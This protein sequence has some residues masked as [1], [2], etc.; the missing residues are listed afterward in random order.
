MKD[1]IVKD[2]IIQGKGVFAERDFRMG[3]IVLKWDVSH[4]LSKEEAGKASKEDQHYIVYLNG[5]YIFMQPPERYVNH[6]C[7]A[8]T[9]AEDFCDIAKR[10]IKKDEEI[11]GDYSEDKVPDFQMKCNCENSK[12]RG[13]IKG[14]NR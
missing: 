9:Y 8:N 2:S 4:E 3:E 12:C 13:I 1:V 5:K 6:S 10:D 7:E 14:K 11:T